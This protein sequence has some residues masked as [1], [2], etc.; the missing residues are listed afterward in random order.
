MIKMRWLWVLLLG[1]AVAACDE[2]APSQAPDAPSA[3]AQVNAPTAPAEPAE[4]VEPAAPDWAYLRVADGATPGRLTPQEEARVKEV[5]TGPMDLRALTLLTAHGQGIQPHVSALLKDKEAIRRAAGAY[6]AQYLNLTAPLGEISPLLDD[7]DARVRRAALSAIATRGNPTLV[8]TLAPRLKDP[9]LSIRFLTLRTM[10]DFQDRAL[11]ES[12]REEARIQRQVWRLRALQA[13]ADVA[14]PEDFAW[15]KDELGDTKK[16]ANF[17]ELEALW[18]GAAA[19]PEA[20]LALL[21]KRGT[22]VEGT[23]VLPHRELHAAFLALAPAVPPAD[24]LAELDRLQAEQGKIRL[25]RDLARALAITP[26]PEVQERLKTL[27]PYYA[28]DLIGAR[29]EAEVDWSNQ[30]QRLEA[31]LQAAPEGPARDRLQQ[32]LDRRRADLLALQPLAQ[33]AASDFATRLQGK[34]KPCRGE[35]LRIKPERLEP[36][37]ALTRDPSEEARA[38]A[39]AWLG[40][41]GTW[42]HLHALAPLLRDQSPLVRQAARD[43]MRLLVGIDLRLQDGFF[44]EGWFARSLGPIPAPA[45]PA[46]DMGPLRDEDLAAE[47]KTRPLP[48]PSITSNDPADAPVLG[49]VPDGAKEPLR[50]PASLPASAPNP[51]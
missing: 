31:A 9:D 36:L 13:L 14:L 1:C 43:A 19:D 28:C 23:L 8:P 3:P 4:P 50:P 39:A 48:V 38:Q 30:I 25:Y 29:L 22:R 32:T 24:L 51:H 35:V 41:E 42:D 21:K 37:V 2:E 47:I 10:A 20:A 34:E 33:Q 6:L 15:F 27:N 49:P 17:N 11:L 40:R 16:P 5:L 44:W 7:S 18:R 12:A 45:F 46:P 26:A